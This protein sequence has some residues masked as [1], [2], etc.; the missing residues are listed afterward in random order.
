MV[1]SVMVGGLGE[2]AMAAVGIS[3]QIFFIFA[4]VLFGITSGLS[5]FIAQF[6]GSGRIRDVR[7]TVSLGLL[8]C[9]VFGLAFSAVTLAAPDTLMS[10]FTGDPEVIRLGRQYLSIVA[11]GY[12]LSAIS[13]VYAVGLRSVEKPVLPLT[14]SVFS[15]LLNT[16]LNY[17][18]IYG[19]AGLPAMGVTGAGIA[20]VI[21]RIA[22]IALILLLV[23]SRRM[24]VAC[25][26]SD[27]AGL[28]RDFTLPVLRLTLPV[29]AN[30]SLWVTGVSTFTAVYGRMG[31][32]EI[33]AYN[34]VSTLEKLS[35]VFVMGLGS[36]CAVIVGKLLGAGNNARAHLYAKWSI[37]AAPLVGIVIGL[38]M[39][40]VRH[41]VIGL[42]HV[43]DQVRNDAASLILISAVIFPVKA[44][45][46]TNFLGVLRAGGDTRVALA[47]DTLPLW[48][49]AVPAAA[50]TG[51]SLG[52]PIPA[53]YAVAF[54]EELIKSGVG[55]WRFRSGKWINNLAAAHEPAPAAK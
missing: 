52:W 21:A 23:Y 53:V 28:R 44:L 42:Y 26:P 37:T 30:E 32:P 54:S 10:L 17:L 13:M 14:A 24:A 35:F 22:E 34:V 38:V 18:L 2:A 3:N 48:L 15:L 12:P 19:K 29:I 36:G 50:F 51:L 31:T 39:L 6:W 11:F 45:N 25:G 8:L 43:G 46:Y 1:D 55:L 47:L 41:P 27:F 9:T 16:S 5:V 7:R 20:T 33:A 4:V 40:A 49:I